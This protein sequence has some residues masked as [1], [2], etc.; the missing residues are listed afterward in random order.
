MSAFDKLLDCQSLEMEELQERI[1]YP[2]N[3]TTLPHYL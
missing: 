1:R 2:L 3:L